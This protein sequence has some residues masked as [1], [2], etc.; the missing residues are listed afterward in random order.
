MFKSEINEQKKKNK[1]N[2]SDS[3]AM[4]EQLRVAFIFIF[5]TVQFLMY[6]ANRNKPI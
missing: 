3:T 6:D 5:Q 4:D 1:L 2:L